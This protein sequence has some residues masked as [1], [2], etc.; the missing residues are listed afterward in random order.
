MSAA[1]SRLSGKWGA[2]VRLTWT[3][4]QFQK[5]AR[6]RKGSMSSDMDADAVQ[7]RKVKRYRESIVEK[8]KEY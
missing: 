4:Y 2:V 8:I 7:L 5:M 1:R 6:E 3:P